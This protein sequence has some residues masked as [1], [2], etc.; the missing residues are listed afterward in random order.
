MVRDRKVGGVLAEARWQGDRLQWVA[1]GLGLNVANPMPA[2]LAG[3]AASLFE[4]CTETTVEAL[5]GPIARVLC[6]LD[7]ATPVLTPAEAVEYASR[8]WLLGR[9]V[10]TPIP[11]TGAGVGRDGRLVLRD[12]AGALHRICAGDVV[13]R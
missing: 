8:D 5:A 1:I 3:R 2:E 12:G 9:A 4:F 11:G 10:D 7:L 13:A 6:A